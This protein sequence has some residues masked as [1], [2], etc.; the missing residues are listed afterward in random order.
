M[1]VGVKI[2]FVGD[3]VGKPGRLAV[4]SL[5]PKLITD[6]R[7]FDAIIINGENSSGF[8][9]ITHR[10]F[11]ELIRAGATVVTTGNHVWA[12]Q[13]VFNFID[14]EPRIVRP[15]NYPAGVPGRG[16]TVVT[17]NDGRKLGVINLAGQLFMPSFDNPFRAL[18]RILPQVVSEAD[19]IIVDFHA[20]ATSEKIAMGWYADGRVSAVVGTHTH[21]QTA[22]ERVLPKGTAYITDVGMTGPH[23][24]VLGIR[25]HL[26]LENFSTML[27]S[28]FQTAEGD[29]KLCGVTMKIDNKTGKAESIDRFQL[30]LPRDLPIS[31]RS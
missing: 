8:R 18:D 23:D 30:S 22:D 11:K 7:E 14:D 31:D 24:S 28:R 20:E 16:F 25:T 5:L 3:V 26:V 2:A 17:L 27:P 15:A 21:V 1:E 29:I 19:S 9:G 12:Q 10:I 4:R 13:D 6:S